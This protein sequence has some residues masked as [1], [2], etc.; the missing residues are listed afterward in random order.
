MNKIKALNPKQEAFLRRVYPFISANPTEEYDI[1]NSTSNRIR[2][3]RFLSSVIHK[4][5]LLN[6]YTED[7]KPYL[8]F[9]TEHFKSVPTL[10]KFKIIL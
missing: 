4:V 7:E 9:I 3:G 2:D 8:E 6:E 10:Q 5:L 1:R